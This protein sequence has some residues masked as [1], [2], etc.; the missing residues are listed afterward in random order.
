LEPTACRAGPAPN[1]RLAL[2]AGLSIMLVCGSLLAIGPSLARPTRETGCGDWRWPVKTLSD[3]RR[4][5]VHFSPIHRTV[6]RLRRRT[7][8]S[9]LDATT[10]RITG[11]EFHTWTLRARPRKAKISADGDVHLVISAPKHPHRTMIVEFPKR[12]CV[13]SPFKRKAIA[14]ARRRLVASCG[15]MS[16]AWAHLKGRVDVIG[17]GFWDAVHGQDGVAPNGIELHPVLGF[18]GT[19]SRR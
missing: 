18:S 10:P 16:G 4:K 17:V 5:E 12:S 14:R 13:R 15:P 6:T 3:H 11:L 19:C 8:P 2:T 9:N 7:P 1:G